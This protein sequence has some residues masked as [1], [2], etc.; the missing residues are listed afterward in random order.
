M[1]KLKH[2]LACTALVTFSLCH[3]YA[4]WVIRET[5][6]ETDAEIMMKFQDGR[7]VM[8]LGGVVTIIFNTNSETLTWISHNVKKYWTGTGDEFRKQQKEM[9]REMT[10]MDP[11]QFSDEQNEPIPEVTFEKVGTDEI[12]GFTVNHYKIHSNGELKEEIWLAPDVTAYH[13]IDWKKLNKLLNAMSSENTRDYTNSDVY[14]KMMMKG[15]PLRSRDYS[16]G[17]VA[18]QNEAASCEQKMI[19]KAELSVPAGYDKVATVSE[20]YKYMYGQ[21]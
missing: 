4:G 8:E 6:S 18:L 12:L 13:E 3:V 2:F 11:D 17:E 5:N 20:F 10:G 7:M 21:Q 15:F 1:N 9:V 19:P 14:Q 16:D